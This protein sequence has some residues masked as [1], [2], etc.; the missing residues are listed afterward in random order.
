MIEIKIRDASL[1]VERILQ[2]FKVG[3]FG[4]DPTLITKR[5]TNLESDFTK[6]ER[7]ADQVIKYDNT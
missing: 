2:R 1:A 7:T 5:F 4:A 6:L 3:G